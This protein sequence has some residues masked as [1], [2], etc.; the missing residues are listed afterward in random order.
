MQASGA[1][2]ASAAAAS[3][4]RIGPTAST[5][6]QY[7]RAAAAL[8]LVGATFARPAGGARGGATAHVWIGGDVQIDGRGRGIVAALAPLVSG[9][10]GIVNL[11]GPIAAAPAARGPDGALRI[12]NAPIAVRELRTAGVLVAGIA[13][14]HAGD[15][16]PGGG[17]AT[18]QALR[19]GGI[20][21]AGGEAGFALITAGGLRIAVTAHDLSAGVPPTLSADVR[22]ARAAADAVIA[23]FHVTGAASYLPVP[24]LRRAAATAVE[25]G[26]AVVAAHGTHALGPVERRGR[27]VVA[28]G[29]GNLAFACSCTDES[30]A[31]LLEVE[32]GPD[33]AGTAAAIPIQAGLG[34]APALPSRDPGGVADLLRALGSR[35]V[36]AAPDRVYF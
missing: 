6:R 5:R 34:G 19:A 29:L 2:G 22:R 36:R 27:A 9:V 28:W 35:I 24:S 23:T 25:S 33:G 4:K 14:N 18:I 26:A 32:V 1:G 30:E 21:P 16:G 3:I 12:L 31:L 10:P 13:N 20:A 15:A 17:A 7:R 8:I 11:E